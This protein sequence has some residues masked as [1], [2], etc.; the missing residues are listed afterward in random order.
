MMTKKTGGGGQDDLK[1]SYKQ[2]SRATQA[3]QPVNLGGNDL[4]SALDGLKQGYKKHGEA[5]QETPSRTTGRRMTVLNPLGGL[6]LRPH[7]AQAGQSPEQRAMHSSK[8][9]TATKIGIGL[10]KNVGGGKK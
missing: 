3:R 8:N 6:S 10:Q 2:G 7:T 9:A 4:K 5:L 1:Q